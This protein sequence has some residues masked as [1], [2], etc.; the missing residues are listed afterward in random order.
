VEGFLHDRQGRHPAP[1]AQRAER[2]LARVM[3]EARQTQV[4][5][6]RPTRTFEQA[7]AKFLLENQHKRSIS[8]DA[9]SR[10]SPLL[11]WLG[12]IT[13]R[14]FYRGRACGVGAC[15]AP[16]SVHTHSAPAYP[17]ARNSPRVSLA[18]CRCHVRQCRSQPALGFSL[19]K[20]RPARAHAAT[21]SCWPP[22]TI[23]LS[24]S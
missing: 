9:R 2:H 18:R 13:Q 4:Y 5:G 24:L 21:G 6:V 16:D 10:S 1:A 3:E 11:P 14:A 17:I 12:L 19:P 22:G 20:Q 15:G 8:D 7:A 23:C